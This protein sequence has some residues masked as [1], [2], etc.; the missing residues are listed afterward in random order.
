MPT[1]EQRQ[2]TDQALS[3]YERYGKPLE[4]EHAG[5]YVAITPDGRTLVAPTLHEA[6]V[7]GAARFGPGN[8]IFKVGDLVVGKWK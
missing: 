2:L 6:M 7:D 4:A 5:E 8:F 1:D 3:L